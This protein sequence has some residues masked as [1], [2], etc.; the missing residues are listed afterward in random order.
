MPGPKGL[1]RASS[2]LKLLCRY[3]HISQRNARDLLL[4]EMVWRVTR[5]K[6]STGD[7]K[8]SSEVFGA[9]CDK[10]KIRLTGL[11]RGIWRPCIISM[12]RG[13]SMLSSEAPF[14][15]D[16]SRGASCNCLYAFES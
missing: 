4:L 6:K 3:H 2:L 9:C 12:D 16:F 7:E 13:S 11:V 15:I 14:N 8:C 1:F 10:T 5:S